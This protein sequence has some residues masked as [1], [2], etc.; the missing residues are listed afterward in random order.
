MANDDDI[1]VRAA[2]DALFK[3]AAGDQSAKEVGNDALELRA[4]ATLA[5]ALFMPHEQARKSLTT[6]M[7]SEDIPERVRTVASEAMR[8]WT[9]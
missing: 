9:N 2:L 1:E 3:L 8:N 5:L 4:R 6:L 7:S